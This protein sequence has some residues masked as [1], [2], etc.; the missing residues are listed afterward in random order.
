MAFADAGQSQTRAATHHCR[1]KLWP[2]PGACHAMQHYC[3]LA[4]SFETEDVRVLLFV[5]HNRNEVM[6]PCRP[7]INS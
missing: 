4:R 1:S 3:H 6:R 7:H 5:I 2:L